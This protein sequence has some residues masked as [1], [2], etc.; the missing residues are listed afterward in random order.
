[1]NKNYREK[2]FYNS[3]SEQTTNIL[4]MVVPIFFA[5]NFETAEDNEFQILEPN[6]SQ[7]EIRDK[8]ILE[9]NRMVDRLRNE[10]LKV[11]VV[12][13]QKDTPDAV[14]PNNWI[15]FH[16]DKV[17]LYPM[18][19][20]NRRK[21]RQYKNVLKALAQAGIKKQP[22]LIDLT[23]LED[24]NQIVEG[25]G[26]L[27]LDRVNKVAF[28]LLSQRTNKEAVEKFAKQMGYEA[29]IFSGSDKHGKEIYHTNVIM[30]VGEQFAV[31]CY[32][33]IKDEKEQA[34]V[35]RKLAELGKEV[36]DITLEQVENFCGNILQVNSKKGPKIIMSQTAYNAFSTK[37]IDILVKHGHIVPVDIQQIETTGGGSARCMLAEVF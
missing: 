24:Q 37:Q 33:A 17:V 26:S 1:M 30:S 6:K 12:D 31:V 36:I 23:Y 14:F 28:A 25:T 35:K 7:E 11:I 16:G 32:E 13:S 3:R 4:M 21:E 5:F 34:M 19:N 18:K 29:I 27:I 8:A 10:G 9:F 20:N 15:S 2:Q 22:E